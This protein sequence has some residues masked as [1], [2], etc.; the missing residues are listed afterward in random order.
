MRKY[1]VIHKIGTPYHS[2]TQGQVELAN[3]DIKQ[4]PEKTVNPNCKDWFLR[5]VDALW[6]YRTAY[7][8]I[9]GSSLYR[10]VYG[11]ACHLL[12]EIEHKAY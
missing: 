8:T 11:K 1:W 10:I 9:L 3:R 12:V 7:K 5:L 4:V 2:Q 6:A